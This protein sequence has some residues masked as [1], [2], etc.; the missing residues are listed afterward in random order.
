MR[1]LWEMDFWSFLNSIF[2][3]RTKMGRSEIQN[4]Q[5]AINVK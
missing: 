5:D 3:Y 1:L 2:M 4:Q